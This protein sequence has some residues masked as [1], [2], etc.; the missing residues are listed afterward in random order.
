MSCPVASKGK[1][2][3][4]V[5]S[6]FVVEKGRAPQAPNA[7]SKLAYVSTRILRHLP[8]VA[9]LGISAI[10]FAQCENPSLF[11]FQGSVTAPVYASSGH[12]VPPIGRRHT[13]R[14]PGRSIS[15]LRCALLARAPASVAAFDVQTHKVVRYLPAVLRLALA[16]APSSTR[17][18]PVSTWRLDNILPSSPPFLKPFPLCMCF[19][20]CSSFGASFMPVPL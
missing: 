1:H 12:C 9:A 3:E 13:L 14:G 15:S 17:P 8:D 5:A 16:S 7:D 10:R 20:S 6:K 11:G 4:G 2:V 18:F 19:Y